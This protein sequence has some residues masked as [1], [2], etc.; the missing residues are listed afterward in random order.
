MKSK[1]AIILYARFPSEM[2]YGNHIIQI[3]N[4]YIDN[5]F[6]VNIYYP[7]TYNAKSIYQD[8]EQY[9]KS[10]DGIKFKK[11]NNFDITSFAFYEILPNLF[12]KIIYTGMTILWCFKLSKSFENEEYVWSTNPNILLIVKKYFKFII[13]EKHGAARFIQKYS[14][15]RLKK[16]KKSFLVGVTKKSV[17]ELHGSINIPLYLPNG[18]DE[19]L[20]FP[21]PRNNDSPTIGYVGLLETYGADKGV[22]NAVN[23]IIKINK[24]SNSRT[25]IVG[26]PEFKLDE[27]RELV[28]TKKQENN[29]QILKFMEYEKVAELMKSLDIGIVPYPKENHMNLYASPLKIF[30]LAASG[31]PILASNIDSHLELNDLNLGIQYFEH[32]NF[33][34]FRE[35]LHELIDNTELRDSLSKKSLENIQ[36]LFWVNRTENIIQSVRSSIG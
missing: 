17:Q 21:K 36:K 22:I 32:N 7:Q 33:D 15:S 28:K 19:K 16:D 2:A 10:R 35:K 34:D 29:F 11:I 24:Y 9:Y 13:Y 8:P 6:E 18:V 5:G 20:F 23:E 26:G 12:K 14:I 31:V 1:I 4:S 30:E 25:I 3:A 27:I